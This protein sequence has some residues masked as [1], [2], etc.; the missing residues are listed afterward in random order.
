MKY[1]KHQYVTIF[2]AIFKYDCG[3][4]KKVPNSSIKFTIF[5]VTADKDIDINRWDTKGI[6]LRS[7]SNT[8]GSI[9]LYS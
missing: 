3:K 5:L 4:L 2:L 7:N 1:C 6:K 8:F 9:N